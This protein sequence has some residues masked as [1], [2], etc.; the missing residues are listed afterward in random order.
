MRDEGFVIGELRML[1]CGRGESRRRLF[2]WG[3]C[4]WRSGEFLSP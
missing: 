1:R 3:S 2:P 4:L